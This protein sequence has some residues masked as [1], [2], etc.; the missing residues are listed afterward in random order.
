MVTYFLRGCIILIAVLFGCMIL[1]N[2]RPHSPLSAPHYSKPIIRKTI[3]ARV[4]EWPNGTPLPKDCPADW[5]GHPLLT[6]D[7]YAGNVYPGRLCRYS[8]PMSPFRC[9]Q[10]TD[11]TIDEEF[12]A[13]SAIQLDGITQECR[14]QTHHGYFKVIEIASPQILKVNEK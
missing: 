8:G 13:F 6:G 1:L 12:P 2:T 4:V 7:Q 10:L 3:I 9:T 11:E 5:D 14:Q